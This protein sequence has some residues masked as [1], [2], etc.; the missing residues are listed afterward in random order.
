MLEFLKPTLYQVHKSA[1]KIIIVVDGPH[2]MSE[3]PVELDGEAPSISPIPA[4]SNRGS[5]EELSHPPLKLVPGAESRPTDTRLF[6]RDLCNRSS[7]SASTVQVSGY[8]QT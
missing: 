2:K 8:I 1:F 6:S 4:T 3:M 7:I 5:T